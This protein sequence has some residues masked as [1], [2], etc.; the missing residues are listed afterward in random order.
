VVAGRGVVLVVGTVVADIG[1]A[2]VV[3]TGAVPVVEVEVADTVPVGGL[4]DCHFDY[5]SFFIPP[6]IEASN[7]VW[8]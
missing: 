7:L 6:T 1:V 2:Q 4:L 3:G 5:R 8:V